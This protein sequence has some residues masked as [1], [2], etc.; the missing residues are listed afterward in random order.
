MLAVFVW[1][2]A[3]Q[4]LFHC[5]KKAMIPT[6]PNT[7]REV[8]LLSI[9]SKVFTAILNKRLRMWAEQEET[10]RKEQTGIRKG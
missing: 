7:C 6:N 8:S 4:L 2:G 1:I 3:S 9:V 10:I 5:L